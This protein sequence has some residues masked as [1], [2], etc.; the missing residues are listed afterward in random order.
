MRA[1]QDQ[2]ML[3]DQIAEKLVEKARRQMEPG[4]ELRAHMRSCGPC[5]ERWD[6]QE[7]LTAHLKAMRF[8]AQRLASPDSS[9]ALLMARFARQK[10]VHVIPARWYWGVGIAA[11]LIISIVAVPDF[12]RRAGWQSLAAKSMAAIGSVRPAQGVAVADS[13]EYSTDP[14]EIRSDSG[15]DTEAEG[16]MAVPFVPP[17]ATG[18]MLRMVHT[19]LNPAELASLGVSVDPAWTTQLPAD[20][21]LGQDGMPR[22]VR[23]SDATSGSGSL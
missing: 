1:E 12:M 9:R 17:L 18:E 23:V 14:A 20:L 11:A 6:A 22:A 19:E 2:N 3:C 16:F 10:R 7:N 5:R 4:A 13:S 8:S 15:A 21:L